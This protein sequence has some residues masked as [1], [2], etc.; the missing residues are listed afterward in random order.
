MKEKVNIFY[1]PL[2]RVEEFKRLRLEALQLEP[3]AFGS[4]YKR[5]LSSDETYWKSRAVDE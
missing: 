1:Y 3:K 2:S 5:A 4:S